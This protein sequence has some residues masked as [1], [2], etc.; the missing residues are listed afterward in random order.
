[1]LVANKITDGNQINSGIAE[2]LYTA[3][4]GISMFFTAFIVALAV[5][6]KLALIT[7]SIVP[8][9]LLSVG[10]SM[11]VIIPVET[12]Q[13]SFSHVCINRV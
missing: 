8:G 7:M 1:M 12:E 3:V 10:A 9:M 4:V 6:W 11:A 13:V 2:K 5:Q